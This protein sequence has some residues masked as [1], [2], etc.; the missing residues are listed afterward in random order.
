MSY[1]PPPEEFAECF[2]EADQGFL[3]KATLTKLTVLSISIYSG[4]MPRLA[5]GPN[6]LSTCKH[7][8]FIAHIRR[9][10]LHFSQNFSCTT[11]TEKEKASTEC[12]TYVRTTYVQATY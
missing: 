3:T 8:T 12:T 7:Q 1:F 2:T 6:S 5:S 10:R 4:A 11:A 9:A